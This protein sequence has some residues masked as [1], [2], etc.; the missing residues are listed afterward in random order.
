MRGGR[1]EREVEKRLS[2]GSVGRDT[3]FH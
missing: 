2:G 1:M 3:S